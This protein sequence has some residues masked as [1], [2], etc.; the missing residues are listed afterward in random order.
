M[1]EVNRMTVNKALQG[2]T[3]NSI[4]FDELADELVK[5]IKVKQVKDMKELKRL[6]YAA[7][8]K[9]LTEDRP[10][11]LK[12]LIEARNLMKE[13]G[14][15]NANTAGAG[16]GRIGKGKGKDVANLISATNKKM[17]KKDETGNPQ[18]KMDGTG[19]GKCYNNSPEANAKK[20]NNNYK[21]YSAAA[22][23][24][25]GK[26]M[27]TMNKADW[28]KVGKGWDSAEEKKQGK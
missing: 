22:I 25:L 26:T 6:V 13:L 17:M 7:R 9:K 21:K 19:G 11:N 15:G 20:F 2:H 23:F 12:E 14:A 4:S 10:M 18:G 8:D 27:A 3:N 28:A 1:I 5:K 16:K 24:S